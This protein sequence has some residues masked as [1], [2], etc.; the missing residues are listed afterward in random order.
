[1]IQPAF[2]ERRLYARHWNGQGTHSAH[3]SWLRSSVGELRSVAP[4]SLWTISIYTSALVGLDSIGGIAL[5]TGTQCA[6]RNAL[7]G[8]QSCYLSLTGALWGCP[9]SLPPAILVRDAAS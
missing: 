1:M 9:S 7:C 4:G 6:R 2:T 5:G 8:L 3:V